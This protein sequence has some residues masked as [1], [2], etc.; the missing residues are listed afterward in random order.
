MKVKLEKLKNINFTE[1]NVKIFSSV[2]EENLKEIDAL[3]N[4][5]V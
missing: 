1:N 2:K 5:L 3:V 4:E